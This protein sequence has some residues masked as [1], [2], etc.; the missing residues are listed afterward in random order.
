[1]RLE[2]H[3]LRN[4]GLAPAGKHGRTLSGIDAIICHYHFSFIL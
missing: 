1:M 3:I 4:G 2:A